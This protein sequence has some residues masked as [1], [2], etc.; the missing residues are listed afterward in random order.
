MLGVLARGD[1]IQLYVNGHHIAE[2]EDATFS[3]DGRVGVYARDFSNGT[4]VAFSNVKVW[5]A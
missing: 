5:Q 3:D 1:S 2:I 4:E